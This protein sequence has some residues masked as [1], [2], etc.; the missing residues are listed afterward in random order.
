MT[1][2]REFQVG[3]RY[4]NTRNHKTY[5]ID[6][7]GTETITL[8]TTFGPGHQQT[9]QYVYFRDEESGRCYKSEYNAAQKLW[10]QKIDV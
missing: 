7:I 6:K 3:Q 5:I 10:L 1:I 8:G 9:I 2:S 4:Y